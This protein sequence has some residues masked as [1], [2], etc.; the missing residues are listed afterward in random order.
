MKK[1]YLTKVKKMKKHAFI[2]LPIMGLLLG[3]CGAINQT[4]RALEENRQAIEQS[5]TAIE[6]NKQAIQD[7]NRFIAE[8]RQEIEVIN[9]TLKKAS[10][11]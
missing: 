9:R 7:A 5:T 4:M 1:E 3:G 2:C 8:N 11:S 10:E 6:E